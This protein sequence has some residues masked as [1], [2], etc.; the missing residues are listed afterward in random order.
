MNTGYLNGLPELEIVIMAQNGDKNA[1]EL[2]WKKYKKTMINVLWGISSL[3]REEKESE[4]A[5][6]FM[7]KLKNVFHREKVRKT[8]EE[9]EFFS[10]LYQ[11]M[12]NR[13]TKLRNERIYLS[14]DESEVEYESESKVL[15]AEKVSLSNKELFSRYN[16]EDA[17]LNLDFKIKIKQL[18]GT[19]DRLQK[20]KMD[21]SRYI[22]DQYGSL[23][24]Q[25]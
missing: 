8:P 3:S 16:P 2:L 11:G 22:Q 9:W 15:N 6:I 21:Y 17:V 20:I 25:F 13:R 1:A 7:H 18:R 10:M 14:Y 4:A 24:N 12:I 5:D 19:I 23:V